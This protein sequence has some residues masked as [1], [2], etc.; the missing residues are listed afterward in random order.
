VK[1][2]TLLSLVAGGLA[3]VTSAAAPSA[4][5]AVAQSAVQPAA[6]E[7]ADYVWPNNALLS[8]GFFAFLGAYVP[9]VI[10]AVVNDNSYDKRL[11]IPIAGPW[12]DLASRPGCG[13]IG[14]STCGSET[15][16]KALLIV[17]GAVQALGALAIVAGLA[18]PERRITPPPAKAE[19]PTVHVQPA[20]LGLAGRGGYGLAAF[21]TF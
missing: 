13:G 14:Q 10:V 16:Y 11:Y 8:E 6:A 21:G 3:V 20:E 12:V 1:K 15:G 18:L 19:K 2:R 17:A 4:E 5:A 7:H 9:S